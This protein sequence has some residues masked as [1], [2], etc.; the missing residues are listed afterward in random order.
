MYANIGLNYSSEKLEPNKK[1]CDNRQAKQSSLYFVR[2]GLYFVQGGQV[3]WTAAG[4]R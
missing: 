4:G 3:V 1:H 2:L